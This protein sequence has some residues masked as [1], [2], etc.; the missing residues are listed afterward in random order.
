MRT[1]AAFAASALTL[2]AGATN[3]WA[4]E[5]AA[6]AIAAPPPRDAVVPA[7]AHAAPAGRPKSRVYLGAGGGAVFGRYSDPKLINDNFS[8]VTTEV[9]I[10]VAMTRWLGAG[11]EFATFYDEVTRTVAGR[12]SYDAGAR[13]SSLGAGLGARRQAVECLSCGPLPSGGAIVQ[14]ALHLH[15]FGPRIDFAPDPSRGIYAVL[16]SGISVTQ[17]LT[18]RT[19]F[20][21]GLRGGYRF[22]LSRQVG[23]A[24]EGGTSAQRY[25]NS[26]ATFGFGGVGLQLRL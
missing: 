26:F 14:Q 19:G 17:D 9:H 2:L 8:G 3:V 7:P 25:S 20:M 15:T 6:P 16:N 1:A 23:V 22:A 12:Y 18:D 21:L 10:G 11:L 4:Q 13:T 24:L 5:G